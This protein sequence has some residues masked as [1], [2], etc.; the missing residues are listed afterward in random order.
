MTQYN[1]LKVKLPNSQLS[2]LKSGIKNETEV[3]LNLSSNVIGHSSDETSF[4]N[5]LSLTVAQV[6]RLRKAFANSSSANTKLSKTQLSK[7]VQ[8]G[9]FL[10][11]MPGALFFNL[12]KLTNKKIKTL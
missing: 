6:S 12:K 4:S 7:M 11:L 1:T 5:K 8:L 10:S 9:G 3:T 2:M